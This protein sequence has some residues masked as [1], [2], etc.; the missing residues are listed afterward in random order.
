M[1][2]ITFIAALH[3]VQIDREGEARITF[4]VPM[5]DRRAVLALSEYTEC[6]L[7]VEV[8]LVNASVD[9]VEGQ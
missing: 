8:G 5:S 1:G 2:N 7:R 6:E 4:T 3:K 9:A